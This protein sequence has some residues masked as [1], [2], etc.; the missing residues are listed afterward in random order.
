MKL[1][2]KIIIGILIISG[3]VLVLFLLGEIKR[4]QIPPPVFETQ[5]KS[6]KE[7]STP[8]KR[9]GLNL[10]LPTNLPE[11]LLAGR[12]KKIKEN[13]LILE[14]EKG[15]KELT[16]GEAVEI[17]FLPEKTETSEI[18]EGNL[19]ICEF[20]KGKLKSISVFPPET[21]FEP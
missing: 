16:I 1:K 17:T 11:N 7:V 14:T 20:E 21:E 5:K 15:E 13:K 3:V 8:S 4:S 10:P 12:V 2:D 19:V 18:K 9:E 6:Q